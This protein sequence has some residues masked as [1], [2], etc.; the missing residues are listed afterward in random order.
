MTKTKIE[1]HES[2]DQGASTRTPS[3][4]EPEDRLECTWS[5]LATTTP[6]KEAENKK[7]QSVL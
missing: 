3:S 5:T 4:V 2:L 7:D 6:K 1:A